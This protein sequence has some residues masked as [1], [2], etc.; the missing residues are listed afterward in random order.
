MANDQNL[1]RAFACQ[2]GTDSSENG[3]HLWDKEAGFFKVVPRTPSATLADV[4]ELHGTSAWFSYLPER[5]F[6]VAWSQLMDPRASL[7]HFGPTTAEQRDPR[8]VVAYSGHECQWNGPSWPYSTS[9]T[10]TALANLLNARPEAEP[11]IRRL[12]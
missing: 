12:F 10:L 11:G 1:A 3:I 8:F 5:R 2:V 4:R 7:L 6:D 9:V